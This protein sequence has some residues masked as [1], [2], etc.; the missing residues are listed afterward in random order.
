M[1]SIS[2][3]AL[4]REPET[5]ALG[6]VRLEGAEGCPSAQALAQAI[7]AR[8]GRR[9]LVSPAQADLFVEAHARRSPDGKLEAVIKTTRADGSAVG[10]R[11][12][13]S[14]ETTCERLGEELALVI[15][16]TID[17]DA[18]LGPPPE[19]PAAAPEKPAE[20]PARPAPSPEIRVVER[21]RVVV[22]EPPAPAEPWRLETRLAV[23]GSVGLLPG[24]GPGLS[25]AVG[26]AA[27]GF[28][29]LEATG[30][31][32]LERSAEVE[33]GGA[34]FTLLAAGL[35][36]CP[37]TR[38]GPAFAHFCGGVTAGSMRAR[39]FGFDDSSEQARALV[40]VTAGARLSLLL[41]PALFVFGGAQV[42]G[43][44][45]RPRFFFEDAAGNQRDV[46]RVPPVGGT[47]ELGLGLTF[48]S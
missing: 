39:G 41:S 23:T 38:L 2:S 4:A 17:P 10:T 33:G 12:L 15:A 22:R 29:A 48:S 14:A 36:A 40:L 16:V 18:A 31:A 20:C 7:D 26:A 37:R 21:E 32:W 5:A 42:E 6:W 43:A 30:R 25:A 24:I 9:A 27:P 47:G 13:V 45:V 19:P 35:A 28:V 1:L 8:I 34:R 11:E 3:A 44:V 46:H